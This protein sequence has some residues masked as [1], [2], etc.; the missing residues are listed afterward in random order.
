MKDDRITLDHG[1]GGR[2]S[3]ELIAEYFVTALDNEPLKR[4]NDSAVVDAPTAR[5][6]LSTDSYVVDPIFFPGGDI[7]SLAIHGTVNDL[8]MSGARP[9]YLTV[10]FILEEGLP[11]ND[12]RRILESMSAAAREAG[13]MVVAGD[14]KVVPRGKADKI[15]INTAGV[16]LLER[17][18]ILGGEQAAVDDAVLISGTMGDHG[19]CVLAA[20]EGLGFSTP[21]KSDAA[22]LNG[23]VDAVL[24][25]A[26]GVHTLRDPTR[27]GLATTL[28]EIAQQ[29]G[30]GIAIDE[31][32]VPYREAVLGACEILGLDPLYLA[33]EGKLI[34]VVE[35][36]QADAAL[37][38]LKSHPLG[39]DAC[40]IGR[41]LADHPGKVVMNTR[42][43]GKRI[44]DMLIGE[45]L[46]RI[47]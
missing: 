21:V 41:V 24:D 2:L 1:S 35:G 42:V 36:A 23:L 9:L 47:C 13:V 8:A 45:Q 43:G 29:A 30:V 19:T 34:V 22:S 12:L 16:G 44:V 6:A 7:G 28:N 15:F 39:K 3:H 10:G 37:A 4:M 17:N 14:T 40:V 27:G 33:N 31:E 38:A 11:L 26:N 18:I 25:A 5:I 32:A 46:P 20:R